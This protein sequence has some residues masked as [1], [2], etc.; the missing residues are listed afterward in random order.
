MPYFTKVSYLPQHIYRN[1]LLAIFTQGKRS[2]IYMKKKKTSSQ[3]KQC[4]M[5]I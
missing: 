5:F 4:K 2:G 3:A 1:M